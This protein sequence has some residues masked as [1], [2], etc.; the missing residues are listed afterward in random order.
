MS[1]PTQGATCM[2]YYTGTEPPLSLVAENRRQISHY[3]FARHEVPRTQRSSGSRDPRQR[4]RF[5]L[6]FFVTTLIVP[7]P[8]KSAVRT[9]QQESGTERRCGKKSNHAH[10]FTRILVAHSLTAG[11]SL[12]A[13]PAPARCPPRPRRLESRGCTPAPAPLARPRAPTPRYPDST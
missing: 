7:T 4:H 10:R 6:R 5:V 11:A 1:P 12:R 13:A 3:A 2:N 8:T 9:R